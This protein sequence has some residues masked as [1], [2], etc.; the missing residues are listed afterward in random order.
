MAWRTR[1]SSGLELPLILAL[2]ILQI[3]RVPSLFSTPLTL[4]RPLIGFPS[5]PIVTLSWYANDTTDMF[6]TWV[7]P[8]GCGAAGLRVFKG[9]SQQLL[10]WCMIM[11]HL[12]HV[13]ASASA[14]DMSCT[15]PMGR[16]NFLC[17]RVELLAL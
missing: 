12:A 2:S 17:F 9:L 15:V 5:I 1:Y 8:T 7:S 3:N 16:W 4:A 11:E 14:P 10:P 13:E 6:Q